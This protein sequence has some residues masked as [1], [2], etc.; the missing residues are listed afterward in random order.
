M[1]VLILSLALGASAVLG[2]DDWRQR[3][4]S[5]RA[6]EFQRLV[7]GLGGGPA[8]DLSRCAFSFDPRLCSSCPDDWGPIPGGVYFCPQHAC[9]ILFYPRLAP[10]RAVGGE[11]TGDALFP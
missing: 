11:T 4:Q 7:G 2:V 3:R 6:E 9:S 10:V 5:T 1:L 8:V